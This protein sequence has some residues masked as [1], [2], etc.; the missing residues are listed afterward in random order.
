MDRP[1]SKEEGKLSLGVGTSGTVLTD[2]K[3]KRRPGGAREAKFHLKKA[4][5]AESSE[6][7]NKTRRGER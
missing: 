4:R 7:V 6:K 3:K 1:G 5:R 2:A